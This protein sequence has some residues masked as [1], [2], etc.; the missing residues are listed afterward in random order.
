MRRD[1]RRLEQARAKHAETVAELTREAAQAR[2]ELR[3]ER[4]RAR[5][6][7]PDAVPRLDDDLPVLS[8]IAERVQTPAGLQAELTAVWAAASHDEAPWDEPARVSAVAAISRALRS[9]QELVEIER[10]IVKLMGPE[11]HDAARLARRTAHDAMH[12]DGAPTGGPGTSAGV[13]D[14]LADAWQRLAHLTIEPRAAQALATL[15]R[16]LLAVADREA[17][18]ALAKLKG[19]RK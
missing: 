11:S 7:D 13:R 5:D 8:E 15:A 17:A 10:R 2:E 9:A 4:L 6:R 1:D 14:A 3:L 18:K 16:E 12:G 19:Q